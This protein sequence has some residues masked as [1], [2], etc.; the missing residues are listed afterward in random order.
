MAISPEEWESY[1]CQVDD[2]PAS[3]LLN[4]AYRD[5]R[6]SGTD[7]VYYVGL[8]ILDPGDHGMGVE[9]DVKELWRLEDEISDAL[10]AKG[11]TYVG[12][13]RSQGDWQLTFYA[14]SGREPELEEL[15]QGALGEGDRGYRVGSKEDPTWS[16]FEDFLMPD[17]ERWQWILDRRV[18]TNL[19][20]SGDVHTVPRPV[21][22]FIEFRNSA[23]RDA[24]LIAARE[25]G[26][27][28]EAGAR[29]EGEECH[30]AQLVRTD[31][32]T[33]GHIHEVVMEIVELAEEHGGAYDGWGAPVQTEA[34]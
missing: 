3:I 17:E 21:D 29:E 9:P 1:A 11:F 24:F 26:F 33:L 12:R 15:V 28:A 2:E 13:L 23:S 6:P 4:L 31:Q 14:A 18:L 8:Q 25:R 16:Y 19:A 10:V 34:S 27:S 32:V 30:T 7:T 20:K 5:E 22:H